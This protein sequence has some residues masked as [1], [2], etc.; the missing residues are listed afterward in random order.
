MFSGFL[1]GVYFLEMGIRLI[2]LGL[3]RTTCGRIET[4]VMLENFHVCWILS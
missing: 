2:A 1:F 4:F 3:P